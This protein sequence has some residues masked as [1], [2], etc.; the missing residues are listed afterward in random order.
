MQ[1]K[2]IFSLVWG[3]VP[4][5]ERSN[6][7]GKGAP[8]WRSR[9][10]AFLPWV[11]QE[12]HPSA[13]KCCWRGWPVS[14]VFSLLYLLWFLLSCWSPI[15]PSLTMPIFLLLSALLTKAYQT[16]PVLFEVLKAVNV[17]QSVEVDQAVHVWFLLLLFLA[18]FVRCERFL[19]IYC[20]CNCYTDS[21]Y[22]QQSRG[23]EKAVCSL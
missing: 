22:T 2:T 5:G 18:L 7:K 19:F 21:G 8:E 15:A 9:D 6:I 13:S 16:A 1:N 4:L 17:S 23:K 10:A 12:V 11:L 14:H 3:F 20:A